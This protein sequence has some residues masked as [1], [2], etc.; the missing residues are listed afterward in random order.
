MTRRAPFPTYRQR[1]PRGQWRIGS[2][3][4]W[5]EGYCSQGHGSECVLCLEALPR[6]LPLHHVGRRRQEAQGKAWGLVCLFAGQ[7]RA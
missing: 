4:R 5:Y 7:V 2:G 3:F 1:F 6:R